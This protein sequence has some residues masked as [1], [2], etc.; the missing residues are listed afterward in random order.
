M[1]DQ[2]WRDLRFGL[3]QLARSPG[4]TAVAVLTLGLGIGANTAIFS[5]VNAVLLRPLP[6]ENPSRLV[7][8]GEVR[9]DGSRNTVSYQNF[10]D[11]RQ[12]SDAFQSLALFRDKAFN[13]AGAGEPERLIGALVS[14]DFFRVLGATPLAGRYFANGDD[15][16]G[17]DGLAVISHGLWQRRFGGRADAVGRNVL[18]DGR[19][20]TVIGIARP[21]FRFPDPADVWVPVSQDVP[22]I[23]ENRGLHAYSVVGRLPPDATVET[24]SARMSELA[25]RLG[26]EYPSTNKGWGVSVALLQESMA[27][28]VR[29]TLLVL[30]GAVGFVLL[31]ASANV[32]NM[33]LARSAARQREMSIRT[34]LGASRWRL[35]RQLLTE[36]L[37]IALFGGVLGLVVAAWSVDALLALG[38]DTLPGGPGVVLDRTVLLFTLAVSIA[39]SLLFGLL[40]AL[41][42]GGREPESWL[43]E[44]GRSSGGIERQRTRRLLVVTEI[45]L[46]LLLLVGTGLMVQSFRRLQAVDPGFTPDGLV[47][48][49]LSLPRAESDS[50]ATVAFY[51]NLVERAGALPG[52]TDVA[53]V[54]Y[55]PLG[56]EGA[57]YRFMVEGAFVEPQQ[58]ASADYNVVSPGY[59][60][61]MRI[62]LLQG[63][64]VDARDR[65]ETPGVVLVNQTLARQFW[66][67]ASALGKRLTFGEPEDN[68]WLTVVGVVADV[69]QRSLSAEIKPQI[70]APHGQDGSEDMALLVRTPLDPAAVAPSIRV[71][72]ASLNTSVPVADVRTLAEVRS[73]SIANERFRT[74]VLAAFGLLALSLAAIGVYGVI[75]YGV[76]QRSREIGIRMAL[77]ARRAEI[78]RLVVGEGM[79]TVAVGIAVGLVAAMALSRFIASLLFAIE[80]N[81]PSTLVAIG[82]LIAAVALAACLVPARRAMRV[83]PAWTL[84][85]E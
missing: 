69:H 40:P 46:A 24:A 21:G 74:V 51:R 37:L 30:L 44:S 84:R 18:L 31:I 73:A 33:M 7:A 39:T 62:P 48:A 20:L 82:L 59:F 81:D 11:W 58:R 8:V 54:S 41:N 16:P 45:S 6:Y 32:A 13:L 34:A 12:A 3:R 83:D 14:A 71:A 52:V 36:S 29:P 77:G 53:A 23:L 76:V 2:L 67:G 28:G 26:A 25:N 27:K 17:T 42:S 10:L 9:P 22:D 60:S 38:P 68:A 61:T 65:W 15:R 19:A 35:A 1:M 5:V 64:D 43:R 56:Q 57:G 63:R 49:K 85:T 66:P 70:Y 47:S 4:F 79:L 75:A 55:L 50:V 80:P 72:V 78:L